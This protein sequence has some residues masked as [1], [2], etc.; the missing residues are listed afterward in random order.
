MG[1]DQIQTAQLL[2]LGHRLDCLEVSASGIGRRLGSTYSSHIEGVWGGYRDGS[3][4]VVGGKKSGAA[5]WLILALR[6]SASRF[7]Q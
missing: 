4:M 5:M 3:G 6:K 2:A 7:T 1:S